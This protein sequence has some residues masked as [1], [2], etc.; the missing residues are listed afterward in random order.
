[1]TRRCSPIWSIVSLALI[2]LAP[3]ARGA[4]LRATAVSNAAA[5]RVGDA[6]EGILTPLAGSIGI[7]VASTASDG[8]VN[9]SPP[10]AS[11]EMQGLADGAGAARYGSLTGRAHAEAKSVPAN[12]F[13]LAA[14]FASLNLGYTDGGVVS[15]PTLSPGTPVTLHLFM[16]LNATAL[17]FIDANIVVPSGTGAAARHEFRIRDLD[18]IQQPD[19]VGA[20]VINSLGDVETFRTIDFPTAIGHH[21]ELTGDLFVAARVLVDYTNYGFTQGRADVSAEHTAVSGY[22]PT[23]DVTIVSDSGHDY[24]VPEPECALP[25]AWVGLVA[26]ARRRR[27]R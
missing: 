17:H 21:I 11:W 4:V 18:A 16:Y 8:L 23:G 6:D 14:G 27:A 12:F 5:Y 3:V 20:L 9:A 25:I 15:S 24:A 22:V 13:A 7:I 10:P 1:M 2:L 26:L 19:G